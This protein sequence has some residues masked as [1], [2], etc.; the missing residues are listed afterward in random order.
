M[1]PSRNNPNKLKLMSPGREQLKQMDN[2]TQMSPD[3]EQLKQ[4]NNLYEPRQ[5][6]N[7]NSNSNG[8]RQE[9][10]QPE[11]TQTNEPRQGTTQTNKHPQMSTGRE[12]LK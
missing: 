11:Q 1:S 10:E 2:S 8:P 4:T 6:T 7:S 5:G 3:R 9:Q 12:Q